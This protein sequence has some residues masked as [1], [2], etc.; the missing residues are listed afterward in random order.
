MPSIEEML[1]QVQQQE[2]NLQFTEFTSDTA[3]KIGLAIIERAQKEN[4]PVAIDITRNGHQLFHFAFPGTA[5]NNDQWIMKKNRLANRYSMSSYQYKLKLQST[6]RTLE[7]VGLSLS[8]YAAVGGAFPVTV[9]NV[10]V[11]GM[12]TISGLQD[13]EDHDLVA[14]AIEDYLKKQK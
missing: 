8:E 6:N 7:D 14:W 3:L 9:Q 12:I 10:G 4:L 2:K 5:P 1:S 13:N 11:V